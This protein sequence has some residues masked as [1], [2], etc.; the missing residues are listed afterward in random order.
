M[1]NAMKVFV[2]SSV[3]VLT[4]CNDKIYNGVV[5]LKQSIQLMNKD[6]KP[7]ALPAG[8]ITARFKAAKKNRI[9]LLLMQNG[10]KQTVPLKVNFL[11]KEVQSGDKIFVPPQ[12]S[13]QLYTLAGDYQVRVEDTKESTSYES[14]VYSSTPR[15]VCAETWVAGSCWGVPETCEPGSYQNVCTTE[16]DYTYGNNYVTSYDTITTKEYKLDIL[17]NNQNIGQLKFGEVNSYRHVTHETP[18]NL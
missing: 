7:V 13:G 17:D 2:V 11:L 15:E 12:V 16:Y 10:K 8:E 3:F 14:C 9:D 4:A 18:C 5:N 6:K 1:K